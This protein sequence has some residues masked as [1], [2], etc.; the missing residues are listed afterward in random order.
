MMIHS[1]VHVSL[2][3]RM[4]EFRREEPMKEKV[5]NENG[6]YSEAQDEVTYLPLSGDDDF[7]S[8]TTS[9]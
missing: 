7:A 3:Q 2:A 8:E 9:R 4:N 5:S 1:D 6:E